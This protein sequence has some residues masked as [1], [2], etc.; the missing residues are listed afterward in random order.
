MYVRC[1]VCS[2]S[3]FGYLTERFSIH[4]ALQDHSTLIKAQPESITK[5]TGAACFF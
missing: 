2:C 3:D 5:Q 1:D 4:E